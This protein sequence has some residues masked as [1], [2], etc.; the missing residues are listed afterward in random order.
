MVEGTTCRIDV[1]TK[2]VEGQIVISFSDNGKGIPEELRDIIFVPNFSTKNSGMGLGLAM[3]KKILE[4]FNG[5]IWFESDPGKGTV[6]FVRI[7]VIE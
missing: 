6:F 1:M 3:S 4:I 2:N 7:P 5:N